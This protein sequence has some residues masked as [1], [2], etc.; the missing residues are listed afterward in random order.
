MKSKARGPI[1][2]C[3]VPSEHFT[4]GVG[5]Y[6]PEWHADPC[7]VLRTRSHRF[8][9]A[10]IVEAPNGD[11]KIPGN[12][13]WPLIGETLSFLSDFSSPS[14]VY[15]FVKKRRRSHG[16][17]FKT[18]ILGRPTVFVT[19]REASRVL[20]SGKDG[21]VR[22]NLS[23]AGKQVLGPTSLLTTAGEEHKQLRRLIAEPLSVDSLKRHFQFID[24]WAIKTLEGWPGRPVLVLE[25]ASTFTLK[26][27]TSI[28]MS[29]EP[30]GGEQDEFRANF[31]LISATFASLPLKI[32][33]T[34]FHRGIQARNRMYAMLDSMIS[35]RRNG[36]HERHDFLQTLLRK[37]SKGEDGGDD[38]NKL[39]DT[40]LKDNVLTLLIAGHDT[41]TAALTWLIKFLGDNP[42]ALQ[43]L[44]EEHGRIRDARNGGTHLTWSE[45]NSMPY[46][47][48]V[49]SETLR[50][51]TILPWFSRKAPQDFTVDGHTIKRDWSVN[52]DVVSMHHD[53]DVFPD[54]E[55]FDPSRFD[56]S[57][58]NRATF[59]ADAQTINASRTI[60]AETAEAIQLLGVR[61]RAAD[62][63]RN[64][65]GEA[66][67]LRLHPP[68]D[69]PIQV[70]T[71]GRRQQLACYSGSHAQEQ[72][73]HRR[74]A[75]IYHL[76]SSSTSMFTG[77]KKGKRRKVKLQCCMPPKACFLL[78]VD[79]RVTTLLHL[80]GSSLRQRENDDWRDMQKLHSDL[81]INS[82]QD[83]SERITGGQSRA[84]NGFTVSF[85]GLIITSTLPWNKSN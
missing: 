7:I 33:G 45:V 38:A 16:R 20:L 34:T 47:N 17:V 1:Y 31:K 76:T 51:A 53:E 85:I 40:Q 5:R 10:A 19:G 41:T 54:P 12:M 59:P 42:H 61:K 60:A 56:V 28:M 36:E 66:G 63:P 26:V 3:W 29:L 4:S 8:C 37:H 65:L 78:E 27:I 58:R 74:G 49:I 18:S 2:T 43:I 32:P 52:L 72:V 82:K 46:T 6:G 64:A 55:K 21:S 73:P 30:A 75:T 71:S 13:G 15:G 83:R 44:R 67:D 50:K 23:Y 80:V 39:T 35:R 79:L 22:L 9:M 62:V 14:G 70:E 77:I 57:R 81:N 24:D 69:M 25:E 48:K 84:S 11:E 68:S